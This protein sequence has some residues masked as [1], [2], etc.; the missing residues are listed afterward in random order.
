[1]IAYTPL[2]FGRL[3]SL[4]LVLLPPYVGAGGN[5]GLSALPHFETLTDYN[6]KIPLRIYSAEGVLLGEFGEERRALVKITDVPIYETAILAAEMTV[7]MSMAGIDYIG[8][9]RAALSIYRW[10]RQAG[11]S[12]I[13]CRSRV[14][15]LVFTSRNKAPTRADNFNITEMLDG[16]MQIEHTSCKDEML[17]SQALHLIRVISPV[18]K[19][20]S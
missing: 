16:A 18:G 13:T 17:W 11:A 15:F 20:Q 4:T 19:S 2:D 1:L 8:V 7:F 10:R 14:I 9:I 6:P 5:A 3:N 12:T